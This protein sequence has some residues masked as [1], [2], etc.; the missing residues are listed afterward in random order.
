[1]R[2]TSY[3]PSSRFYAEQNGDRF[4]AEQNGDTWAYD[5]KIDTWVRVFTN[6]L[7]NLVYHFAEDVLEQELINV[8]PDAR[9]PRPLPTA[10][11]ARVR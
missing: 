10:H 7:Q 6:V 5:P 11:A 3:D 8:E 1:M 2:L 4:Y 9:Q